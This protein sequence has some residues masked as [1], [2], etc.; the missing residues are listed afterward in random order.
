MN[1]K[2]ILFI[3]ILIFINYGII[4]GQS[5]IN[6]ANI[7]KINAQANVLVKRFC[8]CI[9]KVGTTNGISY[10]QK[11][12]IISDAGKD[13]YN[14]YEDPRIMITTTSIGQENPKPI[15]T[16]LNNLL[17]QSSNNTLKKRK[18]EIRYVKIFLDGVPEDW[19]LVK[20]LS[21][22]CK[23]YSRKVDLY[24]TYRVVDI[25]NK[26]PERRNIEYTEKDKKVMD[27]YVI[28]KPEGTQPIVRLGDIS[29]SECLDNRKK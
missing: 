22:G 23:L 9:V 5:S 2:K 8:D 28:I 10:K 3:L 17:I 7:S 14:Y 12:R 19:K 16:Y 20:K 21:D 6:D 13:F 27:V 29:R 11:K 18:Y 25:F 15:H 26:N 1:M 4:H 24:Q